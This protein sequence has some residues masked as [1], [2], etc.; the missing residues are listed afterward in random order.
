MNLDYA[1]TANWDY[2]VGRTV[3]D[4]EHIASNNPGDPGYLA[5]F[6]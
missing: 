3:F 2:M 5:V 4:S 6:A 1:V